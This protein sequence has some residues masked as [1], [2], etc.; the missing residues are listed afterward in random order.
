M[1][2]EQRLKRRE[3]IRNFSIIAHID[4]GKS[5]LADRI[6]ENTKSVETRDM[7]D[8]LL[9][10]MDLERERGITIKLNAA[11]LKY[12]AKDGN[13]Y[14]FHLIDTP[15][16]V[17]FTYEVSRSLAACEGAI[18]VVDAAQGIEA[19]TL[20]NVY[21][22]LD[23]E[24]E[25]MPVINKIDLPAA[26]P[27]RV[28]QE[29]EDMIGLDQDDVVLASAKSNI[30]I[31]EILEKIV[32]VVP[33]PDGDPEAPLKALIFDSE[34]DPYRGVISSIRI[35]DGVV[36]AGDK[37]RMMATGKEFEVTEVGIN[38]PKQLPVD[39]LT[40]GDV[41]YI[42]ASIKNVDDS[43]VGDTITLASRPASEPLQGYKKMNPMVY[44]GLFPIDN[45]NYNDLREALEKLQLNDASLEFEPESSQALG[46]G[47][48]TG[49]LGMLHMEIIQERIEREFGIELIAT[50]PS[51]IYQCILRDGSEV[52]VDN[53]AQ[54]PD[55]DKIDKI[56]EPYVRATMMV[57]NDYVGAVMELCQRKRGQ[58]INMDYLDDIRVNI[59][60][61]L[62]LA[63][64]VFDF[65]DQLKS[66]T[67]GYASFDYEFIE[68]KESN[69][70]KMDILLNGDKVD[71]LSFI[72]HRDFAYER[73]KALVEKLKTL[74]PR[75]QFEVPVQAAIGQKI[76]A[77][78]NIKSMGKNV[79]AKCYGGDISR[80]RKL[81]EKQKAGKAK[82]K[83][84]GNVE[85]PQDAFLAVLKMDDE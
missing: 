83:A 57:P 20:A 2:N 51:V 7:Q 27:E 82:M 43:R 1:D 75:Q 49:F 8:Q 71:A 63:E 45:K 52:T 32:E 78:T 50:A 53:P 58:F 21:L 18:L 38:T 17:D 80:K 66:N 85:I 41:G 29:I 47:Y 6:L 84:V 70:V 73:G 36:K 68:N 61:E 40:V 46:F 9:D 54:M 56:F 65:F 81:L 34:Y 5:T 55:R 15:G 10:S 37:I 59:V 28:K 77:R 11:R 16:H 48:R 33:A 13:T 44:C 39:E 30:G 64:V 74:I 42:I 4:H 3:N 23:N 72:V 35:V 69:L 26:E 67:K 19:Q 12:E 25:L 79:L 22:A 14:T 76:V 60:Y 31:E 62:P 24:L